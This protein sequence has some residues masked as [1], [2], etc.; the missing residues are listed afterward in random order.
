MPYALRWGQ[1]A[2]RYCSAMNMWKA[3]AFSHPLRTPSEPG[4][5]FP[6]LFSMELTLD[7]PPPELPNSRTASAHWLPADREERP[8][9][10]WLRQW[11]FNSCLSIPGNPPRRLPTFTCYSGTV[12][13]AIISAS[14]NRKSEHGFKFRR[15]AEDFFRHD[16]RL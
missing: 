1:K 3:L 10:L 11:R 9:G 6:Q 13:Q 15:A 4:T 7:G 5:L 8:N 12:S 14:R 16:S 2:A